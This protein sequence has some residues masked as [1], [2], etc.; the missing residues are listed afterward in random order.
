MQA[1]R[2]LVVRVQL[3]TS[4]FMKIGGMKMNTSLKWIKDMVPGLSVSPQ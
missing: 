4:V 1:G 2:R 3:G